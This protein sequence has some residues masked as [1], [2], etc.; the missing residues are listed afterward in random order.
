MPD[1][2]RAG[3]RPR[4]RMPGRSRIQRLPSSTRSQSVVSKSH[5]VIGA[6]LSRSIIRAK[7]TPSPNGQAS[8]QSRSE[9]A[10]E[11]KTP[12]PLSKTLKNRLPRKCFRLWE[13]LEKHYTPKPKSI[14][15]S[16]RKGG[17]KWYPGN[18]PNAGHSASSRQVQRQETERQQRQQRF[19]RGV[20]GLW[21]R[22]SGKHRPDQIAERTGK[23]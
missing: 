22:L 8:R 19:S 1:K 4:F 13:A 5:V 21:D 20:K 12:C 16:L 9:A 10:W 11:M 18:A 7:F 15:L 6:V 23:L 14:I 3:A 2:T 17:R